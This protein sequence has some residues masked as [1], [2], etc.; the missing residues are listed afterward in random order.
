MVWAAASSAAAYFA[1]W[2]AY[3]VALAIVENVCH[4]TCNSGKAASLWE[5]YALTV[6]ALEKAASLREARSSFCA[7]RKC[8]VTEGLEGK[9]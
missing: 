4:C 2:K 5:A 3:V 7:F 1:L 9:D 8:P 6:V